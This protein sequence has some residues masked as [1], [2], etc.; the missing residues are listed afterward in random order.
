M[1][2]L[3]ISFHWEESIRPAGFLSRKTT[4]FCEISFFLFSYGSKWECGVVR[5][6]SLVRNKTCGKQRGALG[7]GTWAIRQDTDLKKFLGA[8]EQSVSSWSWTLE[9]T[10]G[11]RPWPCS[12]QLGDEFF[13]KDSLRSPRSCVCH[14]TQHLQIAAA[15]H[16]NMSQH[17][18]ASCS[19]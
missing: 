11:G 12:S 9:L 5:A 3:S 17:R 4:E 10:A 6:D 14:K 18:F 7:L 2:L 13:L 8:L 15:S 19:S 1:Y 16:L